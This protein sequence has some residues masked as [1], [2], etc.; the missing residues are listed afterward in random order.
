MSNILSTR[1][2]LEM[3]SIH[4]W[5]SDDDWGLVVREHAEKA[6]ANKLSEACKEFEDKNQEIIDDAQE[7]KHNSKRRWML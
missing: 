3:V 2:R 6:K 7:R 5:P 4:F 1:T